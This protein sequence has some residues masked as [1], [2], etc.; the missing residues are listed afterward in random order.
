MKRGKGICAAILM[1]L[2]GATAATVVSASA[3]TA[4]GDQ[5]ASPPAVTVVADTTAM[6]PAATVATDVAT[7]TQASDPGG[8][9][10]AGGGDGSGGSGG[11]GNGPAV[12]ASSGGG[13]GSAGNGSAGSGNSSGGSAGSGSQGSSGGGGNP[14]GGTDGRTGTPAPP[15]DSTG[16]GSNRGQSGGGSSGTTSSGSQGQSSGAAP[17]RG[18]GSNGG[19]SGSSGNGGGNTLGGQSGR[20]TSNCHVGEQSPAGTVTFTPAPTQTQAQA[21]AGTPTP[22]QTTPIAVTGPRPPKSSHGLSTSTYSTSAKAISPAPRVTPTGLVGASVGVTV[23]S[24]ARAGLT[25]TSSRLPSGA[26]SSISTLLG[27]APTAPAST[28]SGDRT[29]HGG[30][31]RPG[32]TQPIAQ[33]TIIQS[34]EQ[35]VPPEIWLALAA[36][37]AFGGLS[38]G[39]ALYSGHRVRRQAN[40]FAAMSTAALTDQL[41]GVLNRRGFLEAVERELARAR[42]YDRGFVLAYVDVRGLKGV[43]DTEGHRAGDELLKEAAILLQ[44]SARADDVVGRL[45]GDEMGLLLIEQGADGA[46]AVRRRVAAQVPVR[47]EKLGL[48]SS[49]DL[50][51][52][53]AAFPE[54]GETVDD[55]L[56]VADERLYEQRGIDLLDR[57]PAPAY[58]DA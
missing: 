5:A 13:N 37:L 42:R 7:A 56:R 46:G 3:D 19:G 14:Q 48:H 30:S 4:G 1:G 21:Q 17:G 18:S 40:A 22:T 20:C 58:A 31:Q 57:T 29:T 50:T 32:V 44:D 51:I 12:G 11:S 33:Q 49:W 53:T 24:A 9:R 26:P 43:N 55:L 36:A 39:W 28:H 47:R 34:I 10:G 27:S 41:T 35:V 54:D 45:G 38:A 15:A 52:G 16:T 8:T 25:S 6:A 23:S 2:C